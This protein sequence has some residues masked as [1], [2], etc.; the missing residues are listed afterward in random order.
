MESNIILI[1]TK[2]LYHH[3][4][5]RNYNKKD[6]AELADSIKAN[7][8]FQNLTVVPYSAADHAALSVQKPDDAYVV[9]IGNRRLDASV[10]AG[11]AEVPCVVAQMD[12]K[13]Q[14]KTMTQENL[15]R[16]DMTARE[17]GESFQ[18]LLDL[19]DTVQTVSKDTGFSV[20]TVRNRLSLLKL[21]GDK[22][23]KA[24]ARG[25][26][27]MDFLE[28]SKLKD[29]DLRDQV[30]DHAGTPN[31]QN[32][33]K[34]AKETEK[35]REILAQIRPV[36]EGFA[37]FVES[38][39]A[40]QYIAV[41]GYCYNK[42]APEVPADASTRKYWFTVTSPG[43]SNEYITLYGETIV[44]DKTPEEA[45]QEALKEKYQADEKQLNAAS[46]RAYELRRAF[47]KD[48]P[49]TTVR[50]HMGDIATFLGTEIVLKGREQYG[51]YLDNRC[52]EKDLAEFLGVPF[53]KNE[54]EVPLEELEAAFRRVPEYALFVQVYLLLE[55]KEAKYFNFPW[56]NSLSYCV[57]KHKSCVLLDRI[58]GLLKT[59]GY[60]LSDEEKALQDGTHELFWKPPVQG[61][62]QNIA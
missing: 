50:K 3:P 17:Q 61:N 51:K 22:L 40:G 11:L 23:D 21:D 49:A 19:G 55:D 60:E 31:F 13:T 56:E 44:R 2:K 15:L 59:F 5:N 28:V 12:L 20:Q 24:D 4:N 52:K 53:K 30:M 16:K 58:Y 8:I 36:I 35:N 29:Q 33:L 46:K 9:V 10:I 47:V 54:K 34:V 38:R 57:P 62:T 6:L 7:G 45:A 43:A 26:S 37:T 39:P 48:V 41:Y 14:I 27:L 42:E 25:A 18:L 32:F 1:P